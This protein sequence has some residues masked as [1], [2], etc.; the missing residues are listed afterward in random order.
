MSIAMIDGAFGDGMLTWL[1]SWP[2]PVLQYSRSPSATG[3]QLARLCG[4][5]PTSSIM[6]NIQMMS[7][8]FLPVSFSSLIGP[9]F[10]LSWKPSMSAA[11]IWPRLRREVGDAADDQRRAGDALERP[12]VGAA[13]RQLL[14]RRLPQE[15]AGRLAERHQ[16][17]AIAGLLRI[18]HRL[19]VGAD[20]CT[21]P[22]PTVGLPYDCEPSSA[23]HFTFFPVLT[24]QV[25]GRPVI[26]DTMLRL[27]VPP[28]IGQSA[29]DTA[30]ARGENEDAT[31]NDTAHAY[32]L[33]E[34]LTL[35]KYMSEMPS[36]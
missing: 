6:S 27:G 1:S 29:A 7:G 17:A 3:E 19:V 4:N 2:L 31:Q 8:S 21:T 32:W 12:V 23:T 14:E 36:A 33:L 11:T 16:H 20:R 28:H 26:G 9:S 18:A 24:S 34:T 13:R 15:L 5:A 10:S 22:P 35:S 25:V 30:D